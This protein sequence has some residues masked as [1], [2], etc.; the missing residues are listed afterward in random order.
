MLDAIFYSYVELN[1]ETGKLEIIDKPQ[2]EN[3]EIIS[4]ARYATYT[5]ITWE[6][7]IGSDNFAGQTLWQGETPLAMAGGALDLYEPTLLNQAVPPEEAIVEQVN[8]RLINNIPASLG[9]HG[10][11]KKAAIAL[12]D[13]QNTITLKL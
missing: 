11:P 4:Y 9:Q 10:V 5:L 13:P 2:N 1:E 8:R 3:F 6:R 12:R 7:T